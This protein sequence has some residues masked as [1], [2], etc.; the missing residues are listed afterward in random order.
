L[1]RNILKP[2]AVANIKGKPSA[3][4]RHFYHDTCVYDPRAREMLLRRLRSERA[5]G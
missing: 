4:L 2:E 5:G 3:Y 1:D